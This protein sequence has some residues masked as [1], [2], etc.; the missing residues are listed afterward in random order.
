MADE[1]TNAHKYRLRV[2]AGPEYDPN[3][4]Q[5]VPVN[6]ETLRIENDHAIISLCVRI[7]DYT[8][9]PEGSAS[10][11]PY[12]EHPLHTKDQYSISFSIIF[13][14]PVNGNNLVFGNDFDRPIRDILP[15]GFNAAL[16]MVKWTLDPS[17]DGDAYADR[18]YLF[19]PALATFNYFRI[20][21]K[22]GESDE[23]PTLHNEVV[24]EGADGEE[25]TEMRR[26]FP[27]ADSRKKFFQNEANRKEFEFEAGRLYLV[28]FGNPY[29]AFSDFSVRLP[30][31]TIH[32]MKYVSDKDH[33]LR[34]VLKDATTGRV[35][36][37]VMFTVVLRDI[38]QDQGYTQTDG[39]GSLEH[40][41]WESEPSAADVE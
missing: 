37:V 40:F 21:E 30:G 35:Y 36:L 27:D 13:K 12:F 20:G 6:G 34:Y 1:E 10:T 23:L 16:R 15:P 28:D 31:I 17:L 9:F 4:H 2:T 25:A 11:C 7:Q 38:G 5:V 29:L 3:T 24:E 8:G 33:D 32:A 39:K 18:P 14:E 19:S 41:D 26:M 22:M